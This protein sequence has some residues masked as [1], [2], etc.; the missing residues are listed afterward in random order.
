MTFPGLFCEK[1]RMNMNEK[2]EQ[3]GNLEQILLMQRGELVG[4]DDISSLLIRKII[5]KS[6]SRFPGFL[7]W[8]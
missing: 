8:I 5:R 6:W 4:R 7:F 2:Q 1:E 3:N